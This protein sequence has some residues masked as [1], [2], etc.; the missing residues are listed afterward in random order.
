[1]N[2]TVGTI[3]RR[4]KELR[5]E[6]GLTKSELAKAIGNNYREILRWET[7]ISEPR[8]SKLKQIAD[9]LAVPM[10]SFFEEKGGEDEPFMN[11]IDNK[12]I[13]ENKMHTEKTVELTVKIPVKNLKELFENSQK[14]SI[15]G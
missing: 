6:R 2:K 1:M 8:A 4:I 11:R 14:S 9:V 5:E 10:D 13:V 7:T 15:P 12:P 3:G